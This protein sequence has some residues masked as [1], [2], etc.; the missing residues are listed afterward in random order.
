[1]QAP[2]TQTQAP[3]AVTVAEEP[4]NAPMLRVVSPFPSSVELEPVRRPARWEPLERWPAAP[5]TR[6]S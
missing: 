3:E 2:R 4:T 1:M 5:E 6:R